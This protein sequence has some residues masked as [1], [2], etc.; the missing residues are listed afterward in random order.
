MK[1]DP[2]GRLIIT[3]AKKAEPYF[4]EDVI[5]LGVP[6]GRYTYGYAQIKPGHWRSIRS[7][8]SFCSLAS[9]I[10]V[11]GTHHPTDWV[12][13]NPI[14]YRPD[15]GIIRHPVT[16]PDEFQ[17][18]NQRVEIRND[19]WI[20]ERAVILRPC[21]LG[22][23]CV[24]AAGALVTKD[25]P[26]YAVVAGVPARIIR[27]RIPEELIEAMLKISWWDWSADQIRENAGDFYDPVS[28]VSKY[29]V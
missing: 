10:S 29:A 1:R 15:R 23:G 22:H 4:E 25:V 27:Y 24:V 16:M 11:P 7:V 14:I 28:F 26:P 12:T 5:Y 2:A 20:G 9:D 21:V 6:V 17:R 13:T 8:G 18:K 19:V 3:D